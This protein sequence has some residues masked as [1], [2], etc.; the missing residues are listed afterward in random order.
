MKKEF[1]KILYVEHGLNE[2]LSAQKLEGY[3]SALDF[4]CLFTVVPNVFVALEF[5]EHTA[6]DMV[7]A[8]YDL[9]QLNA[10]EMTKIL[11]CVGNMT[12]VVLIAKEEERKKFEKDPNLHYISTILKKTFFPSELCQAILSMNSKSKRKRQEEGVHGIFLEKQMDQVKR[13]SPLLPIQPK[14][15]FYNTAEL[16]NYILYLQ[17]LLVR[18]KQVNPAH[19]YLNDMEAM[20][21]VK[22]THHPV[23][24]GSCEEWEAYDRLA[25]EVKDPWTNLFG[26]KEDVVASKHLNMKMEADMS[27]ALALGKRKRV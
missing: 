23:S 6:Y 16:E 27:F 14:Q 21:R 5:L 2:R 20:R 8:N 7:I 12:P 17:Q 10:M 22:M 1:V 13:S 3:T 4:L 19:H 25:L 26:I 11:R 18:S 24:P 9:P 15:S